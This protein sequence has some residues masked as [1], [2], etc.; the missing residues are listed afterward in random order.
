[1]QHQ[2]TAKMWV[3]IPMTKLEAIHEASAQDFFYTAAALSDIHVATP[4]KDLERMALC[5][6]D[7]IAR[8]EKFRRDLSVFYRVIEEE[9]INVDEAFRSEAV[10]LRMRTK[11]GLVKSRVHQAYIDPKIGYFHPILNEWRPFSSGEVEEVLKK[12]RFGITNIKAKYL[13]MF[14]G[15]RKSRV[16]KIYISLPIEGSLRF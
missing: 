7:G 6:C 3:H 12:S 5:E 4:Q 10:R 11:V 8:L 15:G 14:S 13:K 9:I 1:M 16:K 2:Q